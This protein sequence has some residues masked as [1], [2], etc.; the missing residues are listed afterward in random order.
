MSSVAKILTVL[1][2]LFG[3][4]LIKGWVDNTI[5][6][7]TLGKNISTL[8]LVL[9]SCIIV[10]LADKYLLNVNYCT[11]GLSFKNIHI[12]FLMG[13][14]LIIPLIVLSSLSILILDKKILTESLGLHL[15]FSIGISALLLSIYEEFIFRGF[16][17]LTIFKSTG[18]VLNTGLIS[19]SIFTLFHLNTIIQ[20]GLIILLINIFFASILLNYL[21]F[22]YSSIWV[23][24]GFHFGNNFFWNIIDSKNA[25][26]DSIVDQ[27]Y[28]ILIQL[29][30]T[31]GVIIFSV[32][33]A[34][35]YRK[36]KKK[37]TFGQYYSTKNSD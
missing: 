2:V 24:I 20:D 14:L 29:I 8:S 37:L 17:S 34:R 11:S 31:I 4:S 33:I 32:I 5:F 9:F 22:Y 16:I 23:P 12:N 18:S 25:E 28:N 15:L 19:S 13:V 3:L 27:Q 36:L 26:I 7:T 1:L 21:F 35:K 6:Q 10:I 30:Y